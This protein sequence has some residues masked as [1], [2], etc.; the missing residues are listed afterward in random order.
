LI[1]SERYVPLNWRFVSR[2]SIALGNLKKMEIE[3][4]T[5][6]G[7]FGP[8]ESENPKKKLKFPRCMSENGILKKNL[9]FFAIFTP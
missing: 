1:H 7:Q 9:R 4:K 8:G 3:V 5:D 6:S 2:A